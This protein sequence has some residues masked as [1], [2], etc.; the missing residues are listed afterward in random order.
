M[1]SLLLIARVVVSLGAVVGL[2][3]FTSRRMGATRAQR[4]KGEATV[5][6]VDR[7]ALGKHAGVAVLAVG[8]RRLLVGFGEQQVTL[9]SELAPVLDDSGR[10]QVP[11]PRAPG[12]RQAQDKAAAAPA[13]AELTHEAAA[14]E[15]RGS[16]DPAGAEEVLDL[17][18]AFRAN[19]SAAHP[20]M[21]V[22]RA[23]AAAG[24]PATWPSA[25]HLAQPAPAPSPA[26]PAPAPSSD[27]QRNDAPHADAAERAS[28][29]ALAGSVLSPQTW[30]DAVAA[31]QDRTVRR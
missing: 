19:T 28:S 15:T 10:G 5:R 4:T 6:L 24:V 11:A 1:D 29:S 27:A 3:W 8:H 7:T 16:G 14:A 26:R 9:L 22:R 18:E 2:V 31:L 12:R 20:Q 30:R 13:R 21:S 25:P 23:P 17:V